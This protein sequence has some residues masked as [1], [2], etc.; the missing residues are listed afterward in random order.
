MALTWNNALK[1]G[2][3]QIDQEHQQLI[4][5]MNLLY[6]AIRL[7]QGMAEIKNIMAFLNS[8]VYKHFGNEENCM[9][10]YKCPVAAENKAAHAQFISALN[11]IN[12]E[13]LAKGPST[14]LAIAVN[15]NLLE[16][17]ANHIQK[18]D[19]QLKSCTL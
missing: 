1:T 8:Y 2:I 7:N 12:Q 6:E 19:M 17:F 10:R 18:I 16:W 5:Q 9:H 3:P 15:K 14:D 11:Q 4:E 13:L